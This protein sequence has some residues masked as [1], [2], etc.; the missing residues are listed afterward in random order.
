MT[1]ALRLVARGL[2]ALSGPATRRRSDAAAMALRRV[3]CVA[4]KNDAARGIADLLS[5]GRVRRVRRAEPVHPRGGSCDRSAHEHGVNLRLAVALTTHRAISNPG[6]FTVVC[7]DT[8]HVP[9]RSLTL[10]A[11]IH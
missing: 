5:G 2:G 6:R 9:A 11:Y 1:P 3:L 8:S 4:E 7:L 10:V